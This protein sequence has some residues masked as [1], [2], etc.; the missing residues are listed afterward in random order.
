MK[1]Y[2]EYLSQLS[3]VAV[4]TSI[5]IISLSWYNVFRDWSDSYIRKYEN[6]KK[7]LVIMLIIVTLVL[8]LLSSLL[9]SVGKIEKK[10][11]LSVKPHRIEEDGFEEV[12]EIPII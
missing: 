1:F 9:W 12:P 4:T 7:K 6:P 8:T 5:F 3:T 2:Q 10:N 11:E